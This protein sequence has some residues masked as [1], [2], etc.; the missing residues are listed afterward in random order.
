MWNPRS[1][2][3]SLFSTR[4]ARP[5][6]SRPRLEALEERALLSASPFPVDV[7]RQANINP[8]SAMA[9]PEACVA[10]N[11]SGGFLVVWT[12]PA[13]GMYASYNLIGRLFDR[14]VD[15]A[16]NVSIQKHQVL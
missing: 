4:P 15:G 5:R 7:E 13:A 12:E 16:G 14:V 8:I 11:E 6:R 2:S 3:R 9:Y 10:I 1:L